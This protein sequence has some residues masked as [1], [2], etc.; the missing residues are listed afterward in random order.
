[1]PLV[2]EAGQRMAHVVL[3]PLDGPAVLAAVDPP[4]GRPS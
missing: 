2:H 4:L 3:P 1:M